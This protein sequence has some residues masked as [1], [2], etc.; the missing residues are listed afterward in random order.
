MRSG[1]FKDLPHGAATSLGAAYNVISIRFE[2][3]RSYYADLLEYDVAASHPEAGPETNY[4]ATP[5]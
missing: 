4:L 3:R 5:R 1:L 2:Q